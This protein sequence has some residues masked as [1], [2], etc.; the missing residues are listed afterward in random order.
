MRLYDAYKN[1]EITRTEYLAYLD[2]G[3]KPSDSVFLTQNRSTEMVTISYL[4]M[5]SNYNW[6]IDD[7]ESMMG[8][9]GPT[10]DLTNAG[11]INNAGDILFWYN[12]G[13]IV[14][15]GTITNTG[16]IT[17]KSILTD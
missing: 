16:N 14:N 6:S 9:I 15:T 12:D 3:Y 2:F 13:Q 11:N 4:S 1:S 5:G 17:L 10:Q 8:Y 7:G